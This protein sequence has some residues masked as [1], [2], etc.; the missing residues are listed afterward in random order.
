MGD[1]LL[2]GVL[3]A[4]VADILRPLMTLASTGQILNNLIIAV[5]INDRGEKSSPNYVLEEMKKAQRAG[6]KIAKNVCI[7]GISLSRPSDRLC[8]VTASER[9]KIRFINSKASDLFGRSF[10]EPLQESEVLIVPYDLYGLH[11]AATTVG[12]IVES[13]KI[14]IN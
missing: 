11:H 7:L 12:K 4:N 9:E 8:K 5:G 10:I 6:E 1:T 14:H 3:L 2:P 13:I